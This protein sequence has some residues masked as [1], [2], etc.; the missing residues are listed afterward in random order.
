MC[1][2]TIKEKYDYYHKNCPYDSIDPYRI[3]AIYELKDNSLFQ[4]F[5]KILVAGQRG[6]KDAEKDVDEAIDA[7]KRW[8]EMREEDRNLN[9]EN[10]NEKPQYIASSPCGDIVLSVCETDG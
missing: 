5:K 4:A 10:S 8:K 7:L 6:A 1:E 3:A 9:A 2:K